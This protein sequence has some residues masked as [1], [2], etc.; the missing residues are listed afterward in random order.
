MLLN[1]IIMNSVGVNINT[2][3][4]LD[5]RRINSN[6]IIGD[7]S[8]SSKTKIV[9]DIGNLCINKF[10]NNNIGTVMKHIPGHGLDRKSVV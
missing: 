7:R 2:V 4:M 8:Y 1:L 9:S 10:H 3:P 6:N 5:V